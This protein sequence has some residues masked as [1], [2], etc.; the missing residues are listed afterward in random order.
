MQG[1]GYGTRLLNLAKEKEP[2]LNGWVIDRNEGVKYNGK[3]Y[4]SPLEF[5]LK[6]GFQTIPGIRLEL[7][8]LSAV[9]IQWKV[10]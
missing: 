3:P 5:Y 4:R 7:A 10:L 9:K 6:N 2:V 1:D 8:T